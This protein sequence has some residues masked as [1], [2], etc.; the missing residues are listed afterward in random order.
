MP[1]EEDFDRVKGII[2][3]AI[4]R[5]P[6]VLTD[7]APYVEIEKFEEHSVLLAVRPHAKTADYWQVYFDTLKNVKAALGKAGIKVA[8]PKRE[9]VASSKVMQN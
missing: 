1:Y 3:D 8:Y 4:K 6:N 5:T 2:M 9:M 7:P